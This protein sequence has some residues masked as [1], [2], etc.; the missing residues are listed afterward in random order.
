MTAPDL[1]P[2][3][4]C[5]EEEITDWN[6]SGISGPRKHMYC[7]ECFARGPS[8]RL[9]NGEDDDEWLSRAIAVWNERPAISPTVTAY[10]E[11]LRLLGVNPDSIAK[12]AQQ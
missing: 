4:F 9:I 7:T 3:P 12:E 1:L 2:C 6:E 11:A 8:V 5:H 10:R